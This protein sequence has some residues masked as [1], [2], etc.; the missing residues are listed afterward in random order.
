MEFWIERWADWLT[1]LGPWLDEET[2]SD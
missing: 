1:I 2:D